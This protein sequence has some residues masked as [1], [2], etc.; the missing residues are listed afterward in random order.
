GSR[1]LSRSFARAADSAG[2]ELGGA[3]ST[4][5]MSAALIDLSFQYRFDRIGCLDCGDGG[6]LPGQVNDIRE[7]IR[8]RML[9][10]T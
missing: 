1:A 7:H 4:W 3:S 6:W 8:W 9:A 10:E 5:L 2:C